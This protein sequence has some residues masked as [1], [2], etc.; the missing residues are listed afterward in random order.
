MEILEEQVNVITFT[1]V[2]FGLRKF[3]LSGV[4]NMLKLI[5]IYIY[6]SIVFYRTQHNNI[7]LYYILESQAA[8]LKETLSRV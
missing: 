7:V 4:S 8:N 1:C 3:T 2:R 6:E 5:T